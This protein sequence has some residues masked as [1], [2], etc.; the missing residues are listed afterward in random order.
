ML[1][2][3]YTFTLDDGG[4]HTFTDT[5]LGETTLI[6]P[7]DQTLTVM[8]TADDT[9]TGGTTVTVDSMVPGSHGLVQAPQPGRSPGSVPQ[10]SEPPQ[11]QVV[12]VDGW[13]A[14]V[15]KRDGGFIL[16]QPIHHTHAEADW[17]A[18]DPWWG[19]ERV[20]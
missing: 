10:A 16:A 9:I 19:V 7:G 6:T 8:D 2:A 5:G 15:N 4:S 3:D 12:A 13:F 1:P 14:S 18:F 20:A 11:R 17:W